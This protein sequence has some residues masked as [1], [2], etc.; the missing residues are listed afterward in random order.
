M[1]TT[2]KRRGRGRP[3]S[4]NKK[5]TKETSSISS[6]NEPSETSQNVKLKSSTSSNNSNN[7]NDNNTSNDS[8]TTSMKNSSSNNSSIMINENVTSSKGKKASM[9]LSRNRNDNE[10]G[11]VAS[12]F[13]TTQDH[14]ADEHFAWC[15][16][17]EELKHA[18]GSSSSN[19][20]D[21]EDEEDVISRRPVKHRKV[22]KQS[23]STSANNKTINKAGTKK[24]QKK[25][26]I[27]FLKSDE[28]MPADTGKTIID[29]TSKA[30]ATSTATLQ[31]PRRKAAISSNYPFVMTESTDIGGSTTMET[32]MT[33]SRKR[34][35]VDFNDTIDEDDEDK[36]EIDLEETMPLSQLILLNND[37]K[38][39]NRMSGATNNSNKNNHKHHYHQSSS[40]KQNEDKKNVM[41]GKKLRKKPKI[42]ASED[43]N[44][45]SQNIVI[46]R[47]NN[48]ELQVTVKVAGTK[49]K[50]SMI[51]RKSLR[52]TTKRLI[53]PSNIIDIEV[54][55]P[56]STGNN[57]QFN[58]SDIVDM[59]TN[60]NHKSKSSI[61]FKKDLKKTL[62][63]ETMD[64]VNHNITNKNSR[65]I[66]KYE[67]VIVLNLSGDD[68]D[69]DQEKEE[70][71][72]SNRSQQ[73][74]DFSTGKQVALAHSDKRTYDDIDN[75]NNNNNNM[76]KITNKKSE[77]INVSEGNRPYKIV[78]RRLEENETS[79]HGIS[80]S[81]MTYLIQYDDYENDNAWI[82]AE[83]MDESILLA[84]QE[85]WVGIQ[86]PKEVGEVQY[87]PNNNENDDGNDCIILDD[88]ERQ[89]GIEKTPCYDDS[90]VSSEHSGMSKSSH[91]DDASDDKSFG[92][93]SDRS[94]SRTI[95]I[96]GIGQSSKKDGDEAEAVDSSGKNR[97]TNRIGIEKRGDTAE[98][99]EADDGNCDSST[100][101]RPVQFRHFAEE[102]DQ[103]IF[104][105][106]R[107][108][109]DADITIDTNSLEDSKRIS[110]NKSKNPKTQGTLVKNDGS[111]KVRPKK[112][113]TKTCPIC[114]NLFVPYGFSM[115]LKKCTKLANWECD[116]CK[117][118]W[119]KTISHLTP[120]AGPNGPKTLCPTCGSKY[121]EKLKNRDK[122]TVQ[123]D[124]MKAKKTLNVIKK[125]VIDNCT[126]TKDDNQ[127]K[128]K[129]P[130]T[131]V[132]TS[133]TK[134]QSDGFISF[135]NALEPEVRQ[136]RTSVR[137]AKKSALKSTYEIQHGDL[138]PCTLNWTSELE[139]TLLLIVLKNPQNV[140]RSGVGLW[141]FESKNPEFNLKLTQKELCSHWHKML[142]RT[143][144]NSNECNTLDTIPVN[145]RASLVLAT[146]FA[147]ESPAA[148]VVALLSVGWHCVEND[149]IKKEMG[150]SEDS[151]SSSEMRSLK[152]C[153]NQTRWHR[154]SITLNL[155]R[156]LSRSDYVNSSI[157]LQKAWSE[158]ITKL[159]EGF[160]ENMTS[161][162]IVPIDIEK[163]DADHSIE[164]IE[165]IK[166]VEKEET[167][168]NDDRKDLCVEENND[169]FVKVAD[170]Q[171]PKHV[172]TMMEKRKKLVLAGDPRPSVDCSW[173]GPKW[174]R[175][176]VSEENVKSNKDRDTPSCEACKI[177]YDLGWR[178]YGIAKESIK[179]NL[180]SH[181][182]DYR[183]LGPNG[184]NL[185]SVRTF[186]MHTSKFVVR[187]LG[188]QNKSVL[189][190][191]NMNKDNEI[192]SNK[193][194]TFHSSDKQKKETAQESTRKLRREITKESNKH[195]KNEI[196]NGA[197][198]NLEKDNINENSEEVAEESLKLTTKDTKVCSSFIPQNDLPTEKNAEESSIIPL[199]TIVQL[200]E[201]AGGLEGA[202][203]RD[204]LRIWNTFYGTDLSV[205][206]TA[207]EPLIQGYVCKMIY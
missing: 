195:D 173:C 136:V 156:N 32:L 112:S 187:G 164:H 69:D 200:F 161:K 44:I 151:D 4:K 56:Q 98:N 111:K 10:G 86:P 153:Y 15:S 193:K 119:N 139:S 117:T 178:M 146:C 16:S 165:D 116:F 17:E 131:N 186:L 47:D 100:L 180:R 171:I 205:A 88:V 190:C 96:I 196:K 20:S 152:S 35:A 75:N 55:L 40:S 201:S 175:K 157:S 53:L 9:T 34:R 160:S 6:N 197:S 204:N 63:P 108:S 41:T 141:V 97:K 93:A 145:C 189:F 19:C 42:K 62:V 81:T 163:S 130:T 31:R 138:D 122:S 71:E 26:A 106:V 74:G 192:D 60:N 82:K 46:K 73:S 168:K 147:F 65:E 104:T 77:P 87:L 61:L 188:V 8:S 43:S 1:T 11:A 149:V 162:N 109:S 38:R 52:A 51:G 135:E 133:R 85:K 124:N 128:E 68:D 206:L 95:S 58:S 33:D 105:G 89:P 207:L 115:H 142:Q 185:R 99:V 121:A 59:N 29:T 64:K 127:S 118:K 143:V 80:S 177:L 140:V 67:N 76:R 113:R 137:L 125:N 92:L 126:S 191:N 36:Q 30:T 7:N 12:S 166:K 170:S 24:V 167:D 72:I 158:H 154:P 79:D 84:N 50:V 57:I 181:C 179:K 150:I 176:E 2:V 198:L 39:K 134:I 172:I 54:P 18:L 23:S 78:A 28:K 83:S 123:N 132:S 101:E 37:R 120:L 49:N 183:Y 199:P 155:L 184:E 66:V 107:K 174:V 194:N 25:E 144:Q 21:E 103:E 202:L 94:S 148:R 27:S 5:K 90:T 110:A 13:S 169:K 159:E 48:D 14:Q 91:T 182:N 70:E 3:P 102:N 203:Q 129:C 114:F 22:E 45:E